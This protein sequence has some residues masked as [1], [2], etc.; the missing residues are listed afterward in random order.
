MTH[1]AVEEI[2]G[3]PLCLP[4]F[5][6]LAALRETSVQ[7]RTRQ[8]EGAAATSLRVRFTPEN[9]QEDTRIALS[10]L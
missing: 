10:S 1:G 8:P 6:N 7:L 9:D 2:Q 5:A 4:D 3:G